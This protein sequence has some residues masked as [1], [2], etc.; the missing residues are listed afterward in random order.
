MV[1]PQFF[2]PAFDSLATNGYLGD[3]N[4]QPAYAYMRVSSDEQADEG[5]SGL[6]RQILHIHK[7]ACEKKLKIS[8][9][10][11]FADDYT[12]FE[13]ERRPELSRLRHEYKSDNR[14]THAV[15]MEHLDRLSRNADWHQ[16]FLLD[17]MTRNGLE[18]VFWKAF[19]SRV[20]RAVMGAIAQDAME[21]SLMRMKEGRRDKAKTGRVTA[22]TLAYGYKFVDSTGLEGIGSRRDT[23]YAIYESEAQVV[24]KIFTDVASGK[25]LG[26]VASELT[27]LYPTPSGHPIWGRASV[28]SILKRPT[29]KGEFHAMRWGKDK[30]GR[31]IENDDYIVVP[32]PAIVSPEIWD[33]A[34]RILEKNKQTASRNAK[35]PYLLTGLMRCASCGR[36]FMGHQGR[37]RLNGKRLPT[38]QRVY[39]CTSRSDHK[40]ELIGCPQGYIGCIKVD[41]AVWDIVCQV[42]LKPEVLIEALDQ[43]FAADENA[44]LLKQVA[45]LEK[46]IYDR[47]KEEEKIYRAYVAG[48]FDEHEFADKRRILKESSQVLSK[49][50]ESLKSRVLTHEHIAAQ[51]MFITEMASQLRDAGQLQNV[52]FEIKRQIIKLVV[53]QITVDTR[54][55]WIRVEGAISKT[56]ALVSVAGINRSEPLE[57]DKSSHIAPID[58]TSNRTR[59]RA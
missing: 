40:R 18:P 49:E 58:I 50:I 44:S 31:A 48:A 41:N 45:F 55:Q 53:N 7:I 47:A 20:E 13:F 42:L 52:P 19:T 5:H 9:D 51:K 11:V 46:Q 22:R 2:K 21:L 4:G 12:G 59:H 28:R 25:T 32:V 1:K 35:K 37:T 39:H 15:V 29:Y 26:Q 17:E 36:S 10:M 34:N 56:Y 54:E 3:P 27:G 30:D 8:W 57:I 33:E 24:R 43:H 16:G 38:P 14:R 6:P 23:H